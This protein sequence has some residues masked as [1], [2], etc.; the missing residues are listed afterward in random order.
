MVYIVTS[1]VMTW[2]I[3]FPYESSKSNI[4]ECRND[5]CGLVVL[6]AK[7]VSKEIPVTKRRIED[8]VVFPLAKYFPGITSFWN[9]T[10][11][12]EARN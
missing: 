7:K 5:A 12:S 6:K 4:N 9:P 10:R 8:K 2:N 1:K 11:F 3:N